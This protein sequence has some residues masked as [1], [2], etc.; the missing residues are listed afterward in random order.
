VVVLASNESSVLRAA[1]VLRGQ[2]PSHARAGTAL[3]LAP[4]RGSFLYVAARSLPHIKD[5]PASRVL[6]L[7]QGIQIDLGEAGGFLRA[8]LGLTAASP[9]DAFDIGSLVSGM[10]SL[11][12]LAGSELGEAVELL[13]GL[14]TTTLGSQVQLDFEFEVA[15]LLEILEE[16]NGGFGHDEGDEALDG[17]AIK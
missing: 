17:P 16:L 2:E 8:H 12:R 10:I 3:V 14:R 1:R 6:E 9:Q 13:S 15:R 5:T 7:S 4:A 11:A